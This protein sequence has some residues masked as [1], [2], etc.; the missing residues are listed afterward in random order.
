M[1]YFELAQDKVGH[2]DDGVQGK[3]SLFKN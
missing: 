2:S 3:F 1:N